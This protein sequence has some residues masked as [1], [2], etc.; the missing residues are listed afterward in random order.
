MADENRL[1]GQDGWHDR[2]E[3]EKA[4]LIGWHGPPELK[5]G[6]RQHFL[7]ELQERVLAAITKAQVS[8]ATVH[9]AII[10]AVRDPRATSMITH[11]EIPM[12][13][14]AKYSRLAS[15]YQLDFTRRSDPS[16]TGEVGLIV[17]SDQ[18]VL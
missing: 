1:P 6:E 13:E 4:L 2:G 17:V 7:G 9:N 10:D 18:A 14:T 15:K 5:R 16:F 12:D 8:Q 11:M 3:A